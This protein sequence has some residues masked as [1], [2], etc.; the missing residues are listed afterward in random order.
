MR[1]ICVG[2]CLGWWGCGEEAARGDGADLGQEVG[3]EDLPVEDSA[4]DA[5]SPI[6]GDPDCDPLIPAVCAMPWPSSLYLAPDP[7][8]ETGVTLTFGAGSLPAN[9]FGVH[10]TPEPWR[11]FDGYGIG[12]PLMMLFPGL[13][14]AGLPGEEE[15]AR[16]LEADAAIL[17][18]EV[19][20]DGALSRVPY[21]AE[22]D[23]QEERPDQRALEVWPARLL[24]P[25]TR[26]IAAV[27]LGLKDLS[28]RSFTPSEAFARLRDGETAGDPQL[29]PRQARFEEVF[30]ALEREG[31]ARGELLLAWDFNTGSD[32]AVHKNML[33]MVD[34]GFEAVGDEGPALTITRLIEY[35]PSPDDTGRPV[36]EFM[37]LKIEGTF[38]VPDFTRE[39]VA[40]DAMGWPL[41][42]GEDGLPAQR[43]WREAPF[44]ALVPHSA[45]QGEEMDLMLYGHGLLGTG[46]QVFGGERPK[47]A[48]EHGFVLLAP[49]WTGMGSDDFPVA[50]A[51]TSDMSRFVWLGDRL[52]QGM[53]EFVLVARAMLRRL[54]RLP[55]LE[56]RGVRLS[57]E[58]Y[59]SGIS[60]G[61][62]FGGTVVALSPD[63]RRG[64]LGVPGSHYQLMIQR[65]VDFVVY[66]L[67]ISASYQRR[68]EE[69]VLLPLIQLMW[70]Q[71]DPV[72]Y[73]RHLE[74]E[75][76]PGREPST[77][78]LALAKGDWQVPMV[79]NEVMA[80]SDVGLAVL[81]GY[82][83]P[84][85]G[86][87]E[88]PYP[89][90]GSGVVMYDF[91]NPWPP[92]SNQPPPPHPL[93]DPHNK[94]G[95][96]DHHNAQL[97]HFLRTGE[98]IDV[99][100]GDGCTPE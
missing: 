10:V 85:F 52:H 93:D 77:V 64:H 53:M 7:S 89:R 21:W 61:G 36:H 40:P 2:L 56:E 74:R 76:F 97:V 44:W 73:Y 42:F 30:A 72:T 84:L 62:I 79:V 20:P 54:G 26:Y 19:Q 3:E 66:Q 24:K 88:V 86:V 4:P 82:G 25:A 49:T 100:G 33:H 28:G 60:Q 27:R 78:L 39:E 95:N 58:I 59:Y 70:D 48:H 14:G 9:R 90:Q 80:R 37:A 23:A 8:R 5:P 92:S 35:A 34:R 91:G 55:A 83:R 13:D 11:R 68:P 98:V 38:R 63:I 81:E 1:W 29:A 15:I 75:P 12:S 69:K 32:A 57:D 71:T 67:G 51:A 96:A 65:S 22:L 6:A 31:V 43:G 99:C 45:L 17:W 41:N 50:V 46:E 87:E 47:M 16:S 94:P 18:F